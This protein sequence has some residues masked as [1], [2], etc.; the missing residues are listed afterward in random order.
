M[1]FLVIFLVFLLIGWRWRSARDARMKADIA[2][3]RPAGPVTMVACSQCGVH[4]S[5]QDAV[6]GA[7]GAYCSMAHR[8]Q[9]ES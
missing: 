2:R 6:I 8:K 1:K 9:M 5:E 4:L 7:Q 3:E